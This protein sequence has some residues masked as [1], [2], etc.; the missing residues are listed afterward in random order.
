M[1]TLLTLHDE[2]GPVLFAAGLGICAMQ[3][4]MRT[5]ENISGRLT[6]RLEALRR[7]VVAMQKHIK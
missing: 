6:P 1:P 4:M 7:A 3:Q 2:I 5:E